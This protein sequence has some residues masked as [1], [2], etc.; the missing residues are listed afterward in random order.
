M[1]ILKNCIDINLLMNNKRI[2]TYIHQNN[3]TGKLLSRNDKKIINIILQSDNIYYFSYLPID[4]KHYIINII[5]KIIPKIAPPPLYNNFELTMQLC[6]NF[7]F[8][9]QQFFTLKDLYGL[10]YNKEYHLI[11]RDGYHAF[12]IT[13]NEINKSCIL[14]KHKNNLKLIFNNNSIDISPCNIISF[15]IFHNNIY[16]TT[17]AYN[18]R[19]KKGIYILSNNYDL[20]FQ[21]LYKK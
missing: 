21:G 10:I 1:D 20:T 11:N 15:N 9:N 6:N 13:F 17:M 19:Y 7:V 14:A 16:I 2:Y 3:Y 4:I 8:S 18:K 12:I 5:C